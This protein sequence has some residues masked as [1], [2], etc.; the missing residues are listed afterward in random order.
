MYGTG[1][2]SKGAIVLYLINNVTTNVIQTGTPFQVIVP[3]R[4]NLACFTYAGTKDVSGVRIN[5]NGVNQ[6]LSTTTNTLTGSIL[7]SL[8]VT[9]GSNAGTAQFFPGAIGRVR[10]F[11][12]VL[13]GPEMSAL[14]TTGANAF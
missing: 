12:R 1:G 13:S 10:R 8:P 2:A 4:A 11:T 6:T 3:G 7:S 14:Y 9:I 5:V